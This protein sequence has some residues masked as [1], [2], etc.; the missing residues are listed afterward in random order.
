MDIEQKIIKI[1]DKDY[2]FLKPYPITI[3]NIEKRCY[4]NGVFDPDRYETELLALV[5]KSLKRDDMVVYTGKKVKLDSGMELEPIQI[6]YKQYA[7]MMASYQTDD[8]T[9]LVQNFLTIC[10]AN[11]IKPEDLSMDDIYN[12]MEAYV[13]LYDRTEL[14]RV[15]SEITTFR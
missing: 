13:S 5:S 9:K 4:N 2:K 1:N 10:N 11:E 3:V 15:I 6:P 12:I 14:D 8:A 7:K